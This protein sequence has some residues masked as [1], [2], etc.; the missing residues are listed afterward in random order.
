M[1]GGCLCRAIRYRTD[2]PPYRVTN[3]HCLHCRQSSGAPFLTWIEFRPS[4]FHLV[5]GTPC[6]YESRPKVTRQFCGKCG[7]QLTYQ[8]ADEPDTIDVTACSLDDP[9]EISPEDH[10]WADRMVPWL[11]TAD[12]LPRY[13]RGKYDE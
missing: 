8:H 1:D 6:R 2:G 4:Q 10:V 12:G 13:R 11:K 7:T 3:C 9:S 5:S